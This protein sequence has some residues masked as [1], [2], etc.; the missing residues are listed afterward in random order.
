MRS[1]AASRSCGSPMPTVRA[2]QPL[3]H[4]SLCDTVADAWRHEIEE[5]AGLSRQ[6]VLLEIDQI[7]RERFGLVIGQHDLE[8]AFGHRIRGLIGQNAR[9][10]DAGNGRVDRRFREQDVAREVRDD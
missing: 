1:L 5:G 10:A 7:D 2:H 3:R 9:H 8:L 4:C 6:Q